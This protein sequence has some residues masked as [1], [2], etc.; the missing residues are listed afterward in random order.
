MGTGV[1]RQ[2]HLQ[3]ICRKNNLLVGISKKVKHSPNTH[4]EVT[5]GEKV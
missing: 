1:G 3:I 2:I 4:H 5:G